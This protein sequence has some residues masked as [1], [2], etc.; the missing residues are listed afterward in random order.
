MRGR[1]GL[2]SCVG[3]SVRIFYKILFLRPAKSTKCVFMSMSFDIFYVLLRAFCN[4]V[5]RLG[6]NYNNTLRTVSCDVISKRGR[7]DCTIPDSLGTGK[8][9]AGRG[10]TYR[11]LKLPSLTIALSA[12]GFVFQNCNPVPFLT[13]RG[14]LSIFCDKTGTSVLQVH[15]ELCIYDSVPSLL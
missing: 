11:E 7:C 1:G 8:S 4:R 3:F 12:A 5:P 13:G 6:P 9:N 14:I 15:G 10:L 2:F